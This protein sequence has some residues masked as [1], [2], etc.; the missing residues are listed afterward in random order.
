MISRLKELKELA[1]QTYE[2]FMIPGTGPVA[3]QD[4]FRMPAKQGGGRHV[5]GVLDLMTL[6][7]ISGWWF[8]CHF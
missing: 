1:V 8:G 7:L 4:F 5:S 6:I 2:P 3:P